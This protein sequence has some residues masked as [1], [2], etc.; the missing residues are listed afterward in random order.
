MATSLVNADLVVSGC[1]T[2]GAGW[3]YNW[4]GY[5]NC[6]RVAGIA[7]ELGDYTDLPGL[8]NY[9]PLLAFADFS[10]EIHRVRTK[11]L[12]TQL[13]Y[14]ADDFSVVAVLANYQDREDSDTE[15][16]RI[17]MDDL[18][19]APLIVTSDTETSSFEFR[20]NS[21]QVSS[22]GPLDTFLKILKE[23]LTK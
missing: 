21:N 23:S 18:Y 4:D 22:S 10:D 11:V 5:E 7:A 2:D 6:A 1:N 16:S 3:W 8:S 14:Q 20:V 12:A 17:D 19:A 15:W 9:N 13:N